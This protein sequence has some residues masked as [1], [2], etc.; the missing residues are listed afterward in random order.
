MASRARDVCRV[1]PDV[2]P[3][4]PT[5]RGRY[6]PPMRLLVFFSLALSACDEGSRVEDGAVHY[7]RVDEE[8]A[9]ITAMPPSAT[10]EEHP[11]RVA[12]TP[13]FPAAAPPSAT[14]VPPRALVTAGPGTVAVT[15]R[16]AV[17]P[18]KGKIGSSAPFDV[19]ATIL[20]LRAARPSWCGPSPSNASLTIAFE[21]TGVVRDISVWTSSG[22]SVPLKVA[23][24]FETALRGV[25]VPPFNRA[26]Q[27]INTMIP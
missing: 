17:C 9:P 24:C 21:G 12:A 5:R 23:R 20:A 2:R 8:S 25:R 18:A 22:T 13:W 4:P 3:L 6:D 16:T 26:C 14:M 10:V 27:V 19:S 11:V 1:V 15:P 7:F